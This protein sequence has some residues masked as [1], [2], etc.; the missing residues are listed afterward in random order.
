M[1]IYVT[2]LKQMAPGQHFVTFAKLC[3]EILATACDGMMNIEDVTVQSVLQVFSI[4]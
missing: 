3:S 1:Q 2:L 4:C